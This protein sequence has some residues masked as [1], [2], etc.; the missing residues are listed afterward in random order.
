M[1]KLFRI[2]ILA[3]VVTSF[4]IS[5]DKTKEE[6]FVVEKPK[7]KLIDFG[8]NLNDFN[9]VNDTIKSGDT[10]GS[11]IDKQNLGEKGVFDIAAQVKDSFDVRNIRKG[12]PYSILRSKG[13]TNKIQ[14]FIYQPDKINY[15]IIDFRD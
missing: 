3:L 15:Y 1:S 14:Y 9:I 13:K 12:K 11:I 10:F 2:F 4:V 6:E 5:C 8:F 7:P